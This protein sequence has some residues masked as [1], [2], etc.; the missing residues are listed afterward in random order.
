MSEQRDLSG[1]V[2]FGP[3]GSGAS[4]IIPTP[5]GPVHGTMV[6]GYATPNK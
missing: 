4:V 6:G 5:N 3:S 1:A 2:Y